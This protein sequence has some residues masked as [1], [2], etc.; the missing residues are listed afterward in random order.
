MSRNKGLELHIVSVAFGRP[1]RQDG[2]YKDSLGSIAR[3]DSK[4]KTKKQKPTL[5]GLKRWLGSEKCLDLSTHVSWFTTAYITVGFHIL[6]WPPRACACMY[7][8]IHL[9]NPNKIKDWPGFR[10]VLKN[11]QR[12]EIVLGF[13]EGRE[14]R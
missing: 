11:W 3:L 12:R 13:G 10:S 6:L 1:Q 8:D 5:R 4:N 9:N 2:E 7:S 14:D